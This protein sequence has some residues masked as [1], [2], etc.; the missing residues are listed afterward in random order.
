MLSLLLTDCRKTPAPV[1][2]HIL[3]PS[4]YQRSPL[5]PGGYPV[6][7]VKFSLVNI[8][9]LYLGSRPHVIE[10]HIEDGI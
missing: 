2:S 10:P 4:I 7:P 5:I 9:T 3:D 8:L 6:S 1:P